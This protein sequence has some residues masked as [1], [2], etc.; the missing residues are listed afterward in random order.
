MTLIQLAGKQFNVS[1]IDFLDKYPERYWK[2]SK[3]YNHLYYSFK[4][5]YINYVELVKGKIPPCYTYKCINNDPYDLRSK[6]IRYINLKPKNVSILKC[7]PGKQIGFRWVNP[8]WKVKD[9]NIYYMMYIKDDVYFKFSRKVVNIVKNRTWF[10]SKTG[11]ATTHYKKTTI[12]LHQLFLE[13]F[14][15]SSKLFKIEHINHDRLDNRLSNIKIVNPQKISKTN[16]KDQRYIN[17]N[18][19]GINKKDIPTWV[20]YIKSYQSHGD[21]FEINIKVGNNT[22]RKRTTKSN[23]VNTGEKFISA[24]SIRALI[25]MDNVELLNNKIDNK[26]FKDIN[27]FVKYTKKKIEQYIDTFNLDDIDINDINLTKL[28]NNH[29]NMTTRKLKEFPEESEYVPSELPKYT[30]YI[31]SKDNKGSYIEYK[32]YFSKQDKTI[33]FKST[34][35]K[36][37]SLDEK[38]NDIINKINKIIKCKNK[39]ILK[40]KL[41][42]KYNN[43]KN[44]DDTLYDMVESKSKKRVRYV[45][46]KE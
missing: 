18:N 29:F 22:I 10:L 41:K 31:P 44:I 7:Y 2:F 13:S 38:I 37:V 33:R 19:I 39:K 25:I 32:R 28:A 8:Y 26:F 24:L 16:E 5:E 20:R 34:S 23:K 14:D 9:E 36:S 30:I 35:K 4:N 46:K 1:S 3:T 17:F 15:L 21:Y 12:Y 40:H 27:R 11:Y 6:N 43:D 42:K 45:L